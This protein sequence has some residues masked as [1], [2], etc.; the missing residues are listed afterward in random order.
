MSDALFYDQLVIVRSQYGGQ[1]Y[2]QANKGRRTGHIPEEPLAARAAA[3]VLGHGILGCKAKIRKQDI[4]S[5]SG[6]Q[7]VF[8]LEVSV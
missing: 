8:R 7:N 2:T 6:Y 4:V 5:I 1:F 3:V